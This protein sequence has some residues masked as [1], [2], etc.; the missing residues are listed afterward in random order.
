[1]GLVSRVVEAAGV[2]TAVLSWMPELSTAVGTPRVIGIGRPGSVPFG[3]PGQADLQREVLRAALRTAARMTT[4]GE[5]IDLAFEWPA[6]AREPKPPEP[7]PIARLV[8]RRPWLLR[9]LMSGEIP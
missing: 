3:L 2:S 8:A 1:M 7:P 5:R 4:P 9:N 6:D